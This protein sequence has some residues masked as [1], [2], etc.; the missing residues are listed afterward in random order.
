MSII[1]STNFSLISTIPDWSMSLEPNVMVTTKPMIIMIVDV[2][3]CYYL[4]WPFDFRFTQVYW[5]HVFGMFSTAVLDELWQFWIQLRLRLRDRCH[6]R[7]V[8]SLLIHLSK[9][10]DFIT[11]Y[12]SQ[13]VVPNNPVIESSGTHNVPLCNVLYIDRDDFSENPPK[14]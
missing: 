13:V 5:N 7:Y 2:I 12:L 14:G 1:H 10:F 11:Y 3:F 9:S 8:P 6:L 4:R